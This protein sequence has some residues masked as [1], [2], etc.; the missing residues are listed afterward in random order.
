MTET[1]G[2][3]GSP[4][5]HHVGSQVLYPVTVLKNKTTNFIKLEKLRKKF[6]IYTFIYN[7]ILCIF[8]LVFVLCLLLISYCW[9]FFKG[10]TPF[11]LVLSFLVLVWVLSE[12]DLEIRI[13]MWV[14][15]YMKN[16]RSKE[17]NEGKLIKSIYQA[18][19]HSD[20]IDLNSTWEFGR[21]FTTYLSY[22]NQ[23]AAG[24]LFIYQLQPIIGWG[25]VWEREIVNQSIA[26]TDVEA[27][28]PIM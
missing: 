18:N 7:V 2:M 28:T 6:D 15:Y 22:L 16:G 27:E 21:L 14:V 4:S 9:E 8:L 11:A 13:W 19:Y 24:R 1:R 20:Q 23:E 5:S 3:S 17:R 26:R 25:L 10:R 12:A